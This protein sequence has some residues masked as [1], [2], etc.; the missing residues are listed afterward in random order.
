MTDR[1][2]YIAAALI[3]VLT[4]SAS[5][6][7]STNH[8]EMEQTTSGGPSREFVGR[9]GLI[10]DP[11]PEV[12]QDPPTLSPRPGLRAEFDVQRDQSGDLSAQVIFAFAGDVGIGADRFQAAKVETGIDGQVEWAITFLDQNAADGGIRGTLVA[13]DTILLQELVW[14][15]SR[16]PAPEGSR[17]LLVRRPPDY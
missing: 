16:F 1:T 7:G 4:L 6:C 5:S 11:L 10:A 17:W 2:G 15:G 14:G 13:A 8:S 9:W 3:L 12:S